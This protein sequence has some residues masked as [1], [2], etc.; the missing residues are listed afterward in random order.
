M[1]CNKLTDEMT[2]WRVDWLLLQLADSNDVVFKNADSKMR[3]GLC[4][5]LLQNAESQQT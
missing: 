5:N 4:G 3:N 2:M 1:A